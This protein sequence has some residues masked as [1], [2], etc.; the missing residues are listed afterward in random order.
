MSDKTSLGDRMKEYEGVSRSFLTK[1]TPVIIRLDG[2]AFH[3]F[4]RGLKRPF[5]LIMQKTMQDTMKYLC[6]N[7][8]NCKLGYTQS[9]EITLVLIDY[10]KLE[11]DAWFGN[12]IQKIVSVSASMA[13]M[14]F[15]KFFRENGRAMWDTSDE[16]D[17]LKTKLDKAMFDS[18]VFTLPKEEVCNCL[19]WRQQDATR[20]SI[21]SVGQANFSHKEL[22]KKSVNMIQEMLF[23]EKGINWNDLSTTQKRGSCCIKSE[24][25]TWV[26]DEDIPI[27]TQDRD[28]IEKLVFI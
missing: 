11:T 21:Q 5:D 28:Y 18:R 1:R 26:L 27:F 3:T 16:L 25:G 24:D 17:F 22:H 15:N 20:N 2:K 19:I 12:N 9:D 8:Q 4:T 6:E 10:E 14:A 13:T 23:S 7:I